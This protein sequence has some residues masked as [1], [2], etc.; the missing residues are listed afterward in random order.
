VGTLG[1]GLEI[2]DVLAKKYVLERLVG[3]GGT[4]VVVAAR[5][6]QLERPVAIKFLRAALAVEEVRTRFE[7]EARAIAQIES[8]HVVLVLDVSAVENESPYMVMEY[9]E[10][11]DLARVLKDDGALGIRDSVDCMLQVCQVLEAA[12][13]RGI[14]HRDIKPANLFLTRREDGGPH[15]KVVD[16]GISKIT[17]PKLTAGGP[18]DMTGAFSVL[19]SPRYMAPEQLRNARDVDARADLWSVGAVLYQLVTGQPPF[20]GDN[21]VQTSIAVLSNEAPLLR[22][23]APHA[24]P[25]LEAIVNK[26]L[27]KDRNGRFASA[28]AL[29]EAL[30]PFASDGARDSLRRMQE[31]KAE[32]SVSTGL[33]V[34][35]TFESNGNLASGGTRGSNPGDAAGADGTALAGPEGGVARRRPMPPWFPTVAI[36]AAGVLVVALVFGVLTVLKRAA[37]SMGIMPSASGAPAISAASKPSAARV[38]LGPSQVVTVTLDAGRPPP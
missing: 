5:H 3:E 25:A 37:Q 31:A 13:E 4:G 21:N 11:R 33:G 8:E 38:D 28:S 30:R 2:G 35:T 9:L 16:F 23:A 19:G 22:E 36:A 29:S 7:R 26:C 10:G 20:D 6:L 15:I 32:P 1:I 12:H 27:T 17:D 18:K 14:I 34:R 24:P